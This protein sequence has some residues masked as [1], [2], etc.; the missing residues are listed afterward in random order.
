[1]L[2][3]VVISFFSLTCS[4]C[5]SFNL[6]VIPVTLTFFSI[7]LI[8]LIYFLPS[9]YHWDLYWSNQKAPWDRHILTVNYSITQ[10]RQKSQ[11]RIFPF[12]GDSL[13]FD[14]CCGED[15]SVF[16]ND[17]LPGRFYHTPGQD[18]LPKTGGK[19]NYV[20]REKSRKTENSKLNKYECK[21]RDE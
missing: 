17:M 14:C 5:L 18:S 6:L 4:A 1:M 21:Y 16:M 12:H 10:V 15:K 8:Y 9:Y 19:Q 13:V 7:W 20:Q 11:H 3:Y 2:Y